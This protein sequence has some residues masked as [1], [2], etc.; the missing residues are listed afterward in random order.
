MD[1]ELL[2]QQAAIY[3]LE[4]VQSGMVVGLGSGSTANYFI[5]ALGEKLKRGE[6]SDIVG[7]PSSKRS[8]DLA[9]E[10]DIPLSR[11]IP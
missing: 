3:A 8:E 5:K 6:L 9:K 11:L 1:L 2:K 7:V 4:H 10:L